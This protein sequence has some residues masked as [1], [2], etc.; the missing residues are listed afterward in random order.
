MIPLLKLEHPKL[1]LIYS[2]V[3]QM[4]NYALSIIKGLSASKNNGQKIGHLR[5]KGPG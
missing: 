1:N 2:K 5:F 3:L 4:V